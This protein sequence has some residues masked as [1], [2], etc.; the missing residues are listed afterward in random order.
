MQKTTKY[1]TTGIMLLLALGGLLA[2]APLAS[3]QSTNGSFNPQTQFPVG[4]TITI[5]SFYGLGGGGMP[6]FGPG[7]RGNWTNG[8]NQTHTWS[9]NNWSN[10]N[11]THTW[12]QN[13]NQSHSWGQ[14]NWN[15]MRNWNQTWSPSFN[16]S[17]TVTA[18][19]TND[20]AN[21][22]ILWAIQRGSIIENGT[23]LTITAG[24]G[25]IG[26]LDR[27]LMGGNATDPKGN[28]YHWALG[29]LA[30]LYKGG[31]IASLNG[32]SNYNPNQTI[33]TASPQ[34]T[35]HQRGSRGIRLS[36]IAT[37]T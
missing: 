23:T 20:T 16:A 35:G 4:S 1:T 7:M 3:A 26:R 31:V 18:Q 14:S 12:G 10:G 33:T 29:G 22:G 36:F 32:I 5:T 6:F 21:G 30:A 34:S 9:Q 28:T 17:L 24:R 27:I 11:Q 19:V 2:A 13:G 37:I 8:G 15:K 25:G